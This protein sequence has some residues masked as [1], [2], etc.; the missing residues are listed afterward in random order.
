MQSFNPAV[1]LL[2]FRLRAVTFL[3]HLP[4]RPPMVFS[5]YSSQGLPNGSL[6]ARFICNKQ[7]SALRRLWPEREDSCRYAFS[8]RSRWKGTKSIVFQVGTI[9]LG[10]MK[11]GEDTSRLVSTPYFVSAHRFTS[12][13]ADGPTPAPNRPATDHWPPA[14]PADGRP[15]PKPRRP[16]PPCSAPPPR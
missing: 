1:P 2:P 6:R 5:R 13:D 12:T 10:P 7:F 4:R 3:S 11:Y 14:T 16:N 8:G 15:G 9:R